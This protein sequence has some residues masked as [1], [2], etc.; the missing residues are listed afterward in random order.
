MDW[1][2]EYL[3]NLSDGRNAVY[4]PDSHTWRPVKP[5]K[6]QQSLIQDSVVADM[7]R[8]RLI[9][10]ARQAEVNAGMGG[11]YDAGSAA[12]EGPVAPSITVPGAPT[13]TSIGTGNTELSAF[14]TAPTSN[15][16]TAIT[17][18]KYSTNKGISFTARSPASTTSPIRI[19]GLTNGTEYDVRIR[20]VNSIGDGTISNALSGTPVAPAGPS[21]FDVASTST[22]NVLINNSDATITSYL[23]NNGYSA[24]N[25]IFT[26]PLQKAVPPSQ[27]YYTSEYIITFADTGSLY[28]VH[29]SAANNRWFL[30]LYAYEGD[31][32][33]FG[34][35]YASYISV[36]TS[37]NQSSSTIIATR[38]SYSGTGLT[39]LNSLNHITAA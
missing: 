5:T 28:L 33:E 10:E 4:P 8:M 29:S 13:I 14:F 19:T 18:Y 3:D 37:T 36:F 27:L 21:G 12:V 2:D 16:G 26:I 31:H 32:E 20:A 25:N 23:Q 6:Q 30:L 34:P 11:G 22:I 1:F 38:S 9:Q 15:G 7:V 39:S 17:N 35:Q 24:V